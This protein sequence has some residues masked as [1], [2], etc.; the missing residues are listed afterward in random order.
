MISPTCKVSLPV[1]WFCVC[2]RKQVSPKSTSKIVA[3]KCCFSCLDSSPG[4]DFKFNLFWLWPCGNKIMTEATRT[5]TAW[6]RCNS[7][8]ARTNQWPRIEVGN[9]DYGVCCG[10]ETGHTRIPT[11]SRR[12]ALQ[13]LHVPS[14]NQP[15]GFWSVVST[16]QVCHIRI[17]GSTPGGDKIG[18]EA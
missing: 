9:P 8:H 16:L 4:S 3:E 13:L 11:Q 6:D 14:M 12:S 17:A 1:L 7:T 2:K 18:W 5:L 15:R 10:R